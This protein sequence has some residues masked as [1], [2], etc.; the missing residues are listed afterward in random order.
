MNPYSKKAQ[1]KTFKQKVWKTVYA[2]QKFSEYIRKRDKK[3]LRCLGT[4]KKLDCS[5]YWKRGDSSTRFDPKNCIALCRD[6]H[7]IWERQKNL[8]YKQF[9]LR[10]IGQQEYEALEIRARTF[11]NR[12]ESV[13]AFMAVYNVLKK[14]LEM[15]E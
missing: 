12:R 5:H 1:I 15:I 6:C 3:C 14:Q 4:Y 11:T 2:D 9:M 8:A 10:W 7:T 13:L